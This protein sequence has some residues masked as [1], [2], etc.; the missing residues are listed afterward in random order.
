M[1]D[2]TVTM[3]NIIEIGVIAGGGLV[4]IVTV[5]NSVSN[6]G[7][8]LHHMRSD[9]DDMKKEIEKVGEVLIKMAVTDQRLLNAE[10][11]IRELRHGEGFVRD[12]IERE[13]PRR[14]RSV[15]SDLLKDEK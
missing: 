14:V 6:L 8:D 15:A 11:D 1:I 4:A 10:T 9:F 12:S 5:K 7:K 2:F 13:Y 3:G